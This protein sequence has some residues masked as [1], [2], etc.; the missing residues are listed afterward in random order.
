M[1][2]TKV[3]SV[4]ALA[5]TKFLSLYEA[6]YTNKD[7]N[8]KHWTMA[9]RKSEDELNAQLLKG[10]KENIDAVVIAA[11]HKNSEKLV[12]IK[13]FR[14]PINDYLYELPAGLID[15][16]EDVLE[17]AKRELKEETGLKV[18]SIKDTNITPLYASAGMTNE[19]LAVIYCLC[20]GEPSTKYVEE[21]EDIEV[22]LISKEEAK[23]MLNSEIKLDV[24]TYL[25]LQSFIA[26]GKDIVK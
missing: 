21:D 23:D 16:G 12:L 1:G 4:K 13:Q 17:A 2:K 5:K 26:L 15:K 7:G 24:K 18:V 20:E 8:I 11:I 19:S 3:N 22:M 6:E 9:S 25:V 14:V 10:E